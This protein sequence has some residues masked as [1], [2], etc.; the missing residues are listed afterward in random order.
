MINS[1]YM[2]Y[3]KDLSNNSYKIHSTY[4]TKGTVKTW[5][6]ELADKV[7]KLKVKHTKWYRVILTGYFSDNRHPDIHNLHK[8]IGDSL[9][10][11]LPEDDKHYIFKDNKPVLGVIDQYIVIEIEPLEEV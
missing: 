9:K 10:E 5:M 2:P 1:I 7:D 6:S 3:F 4:T 11:V 8:V